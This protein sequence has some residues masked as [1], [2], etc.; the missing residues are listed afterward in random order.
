[1]WSDRER[2]R[3]RERERE[4]ERERLYLEGVARNIDF[5]HLHPVRVSS[6][7]GY[8]AHKKQTLLL[9]TS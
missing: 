5:L 9:G 3:G 2:G 4:R 1:M 6:L 8:L 7:Q